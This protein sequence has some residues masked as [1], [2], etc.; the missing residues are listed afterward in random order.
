MG[1]VGPDIFIPIAEEIGVIGE[2]SEALIARA[3]ED[4]KE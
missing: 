2:M 3:F 1:V 4:A